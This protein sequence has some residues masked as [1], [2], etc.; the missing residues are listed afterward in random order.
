MKRRSERFKFTFV[1]TA[2]VSVLISL[3]GLLL[4][5]EEALTNREV[6]W[7]T[8]TNAIITLMGE[9]PDKPRSF[10]GQILQLLLLIFGTFV[11]RANND[12][13]LNPKRTQFDRL[14][15]DDSLIVMAF[16]NVDQI[17]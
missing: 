4:W 17:S 13:L 9:Y 5:S 1:A 3:I 12:I 2:I 16:R 8:L 6:A 10:L 14:T 11:F 7:E 15:E